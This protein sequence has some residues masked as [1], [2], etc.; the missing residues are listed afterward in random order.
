MHESGKHDLLLGRPAA[1]QQAIPSYIIHVYRKKEKKKEESCT[2]IRTI[3]V[4]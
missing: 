2:G 3:R 4:K 1:I